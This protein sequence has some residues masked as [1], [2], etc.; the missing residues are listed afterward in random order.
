[1]RRRDFIK[2][3]MG[4]A[5][6]ATVFP[7]RAA[8]DVIP[9]DGSTPLPLDQVRFDPDIYARND[10]RTIMVFLGG[11]MSE[12]VANT[13]HIRQI[14]D[15][16]LSFVPYE[17]GAFEIDSTTPYT[18]STQNH[19]WKQ[20]GGDFLEKMLSNGDM[21]LFRTCYRGHG[22]AGHGI[23]QRRYAHG[24]DRGY[25]SGIVATLMHV[26]YRNGA[27]PQNAKLP[28]V[29]IDGGFYKLLQDNGAPK[30]LPGYLKPISFNRSF[31]NP[32]NYGRDDQGWVDLGD[33]SADRIF[34]EVG[35]DARLNALM[36]KNN[37]YDALSDVFNYRKEISDFIEEVKNAE[38]PVEYPD[39]IDGRKFEV[40]M[41]I[42]TN[43][44]DTK[45]VTMSGGHS[46]WDDH[47]DAIMNHMSRAHELF[48]AIDAAIDHANSLQ[49][50]NLNIVL[51]GDFG[52]NMNINSAKG[53]DHGNNQNVFWFG[54]DR[55]FN[56]LGI[57]GETEL[58]VW[59]KKARL[60]SRP[61]ADSF[62]FP[63]YNIAA[64]IYALY[65]ITNPEILTGGYGVIDPEDKIGTPFLKG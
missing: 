56:N 57:V 52:R 6:T 38:L 10:A 23:N 50:D 28:N 11:G 8:A 7:S 29:S 53:W 15:E 32:Y 41:R 24:N 27:I 58:Q 49:M 12:V 48:A 60:Y 30:A 1:M 3:A 31:D 16:D 47:S 14:M 51:F 9:D 64:T 18:T 19:F 43:N 45:V 42:L 59:L 4:F 65:G 25:E 2:G 21:N 17:K 34:N 54:G 33:Y 40:A 20:A 44:P 61:T 55:F 37:H 26:L 22:S 35:Y 36:Q 63:P 46:G 39:T 5:A 13:Q 62:K